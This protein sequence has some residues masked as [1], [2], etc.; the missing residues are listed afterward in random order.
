MNYEGKPS[1]V[2]QYKWDMTGVE[3]EDETILSRMIEFHKENPFRVGLE[4]TF[5]N[6]TI[7]FLSTHFWL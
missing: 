7:L 2:F 1:L 3:L 5:N 6:R 4:Y